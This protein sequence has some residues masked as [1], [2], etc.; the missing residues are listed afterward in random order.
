[1]DGA[2]RPAVALHLTLCNFSLC[3]FASFCK[4]Y[5]SH[6]KTI[7][8]N[9]YYS[10]TCFMH[11]QRRTCSSCASYDGTSYVSLLCIETACKLHA[12]YTR[13][14]PGTRSCLAGMSSRVPSG[15]VRLTIIGIEL[16][17]S[18]SKVTA[19]GDLPATRSG[20]RVDLHPLAS[21]CVRTPIK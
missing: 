10:A 4:C 12:D 19:S 8:T 11:T 3:N 20:C 18:S 1:M 6:C 2:W 15:S 17:A 13:K 5:L 9:K 14:S 16:A 7:A 21:C